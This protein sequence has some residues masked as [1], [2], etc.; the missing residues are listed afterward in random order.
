MLLLA[1]LVLA[2]PAP[3]L[4]VD[5]LVLGTRVAG[6]WKPAET[7][8]AKRHWAVGFYPFSLG[9]VAARQKVY[10]FETTET[11]GATLLTAAK[12]D[13]DRS[14]LVSGAAPKVP[15]P[16]HILPVWP[17]YEATVRRFLTAHGI[18]VATARVKRVLKMDLDGDG[19]DEVIVEA[20]DGGPDRQAPKGAYSLVLL[21]ALRGGRVVETPLAFTPDKPGG[22]LL[23]F[24]TRGVA[25]LDGDGRMEVLVSDLG[26]EENGATL[27]GYRA[28]RAAKL[29]ENGTGE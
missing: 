17:I 19:T 28:G 26:V 3:I 12:G 29:L 8:F 16:V 1:A 6:R 4:A 15:R 18:A 10:G 24:Q 14:P 11:D 9:K 22:T 5:G 20:G 21:R 27:W 13:P 7:G 25:D 23:D 2:P